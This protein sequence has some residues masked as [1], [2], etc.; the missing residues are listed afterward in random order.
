MRQK[1]TRRDKSDRRQH[2]DKHKRQHETDFRDKC[3]MADMMRQR[4]RDRTHRMHR[5]R[6]RDTFTAE[7]DTAG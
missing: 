6:Q 7:T 2:S 4:V 1:I 3:D 5:M